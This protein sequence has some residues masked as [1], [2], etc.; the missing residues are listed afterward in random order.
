MQP[1]VT[2]ITTMI[3]LWSRKSAPQSA[4]LQRALHIARRCHEEADTPL[5]MRSMAWHLVRDCHHAAGWEIPATDK[6]SQCRSAAASVQHSCSLILED[7]AGQ[8]DNVDGPVLV[9]GLLGATRSLFGSWNAVP[10]NGCVLVALHDDNSNLPSSTAF[11]IHR[12]VIWADRGRYADLLEDCCTPAELSGR[13][14]LVP[15][16]EIIIART[17]AKDLTSFDLGSLFF[18]A[19]AHRTATAGRWDHAEAA[20]RTMNAA[21]SPTELAIRLGI[22]QW[23]DLKIPA[24]KRLTLAVKR[25][26][27]RSAA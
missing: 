1:E 10:A 7:V 27:R 13:Q 6:L 19:A 12:G 14:V 21:T 2:H 20:A 4:D 16:P 11:N 22:D 18:T 5:W 26:F 25:L 17:R 8:I 24:G 15:A 23:L 3:E 9:L